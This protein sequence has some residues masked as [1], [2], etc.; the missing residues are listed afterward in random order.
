MH[1]RALRFFYRDRIGQSKEYTRTVSNSRYDRL[2]KNVG[3]VIDKKIQI[4]QQEQAFYA[5]M[6]KDD[7]VSK[8]YAS[9]FILI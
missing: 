6:A 9:P 2:H 7:K 3:K 1:N 8:E 5:A 4:Q